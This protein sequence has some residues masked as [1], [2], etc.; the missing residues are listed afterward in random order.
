MSVFRT[1]SAGTYF[2][3]TDIDQHIAV[4]LDTSEEKTVK[5]A[6]KGDTVIGFT[7]RHQAA[8]QKVAV[9]E[10]SDK[11]SF[12]SITED[13]VTPGTEL[14]VADNGKV[15]IAD[16]SETHKPFAFALTN[17]AIG[18]EIEILIKQM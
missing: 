11:G 4:T 7:R 10:L 9:R 18:E 8:G 13:A 2:A 15:R 1:D 3:K 6:S 5:I 17:G 12:L 16:A 14:Y